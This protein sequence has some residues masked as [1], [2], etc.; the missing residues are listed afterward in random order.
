MSYS[1]FERK[2]NNSLYSVF[3]KN[4]YSINNSFDQNRKNILRHSVSYSNLSNPYSPN[5]NSSPIKYLTKINNLE[6]KLSLLEKTNLNLQN[7]IN[8]NEIIFENRLK[9]IEN[10]INKNEI[11]YNQTDKILSMILNNNS[12]SSNDIKEKII[13]LEKLISKENEF[14]YNQIDL[15]RKIINKLTHQISE[16]IK[17]EISSRFEGDMKNKIQNEYLN[18]SS[19]NEIKNL[20]V[21]YNEII[22]QLKKDILNNENECSQRSHN[23]SKYIDMKINEILN[24]KSDKLQYVIDEIEKIKNNLLSQEDKNLVFENRINNLENFVKVIQDDVYKFIA[25]VEER[26]ISKM[27]DIKKYNEIN[28]KQHNEYIKKQFF[29]FSNVNEKNMIF[30]SEQIADTRTEINNEFNRINKR[31]IEKFECL[32]NDMEQICNRIYKYEDLLKSYDKE[33]HTIKNQI[34]KYLNHFNSKIDVLFVNEKIIHNIEM[35]TIREE[36]NKIIKALNLQNENINNKIKGNQ[37][38]PNEKID[39]IQTINKLENKLNDINDKYFNLINKLQKNQDMIEVKLIMDEISSKVDSSYLFELI[40]KM[41]NNNNI[42]NNNILSNNN[43][44]NE[45][46]NDSKGKIDEKYMKE[47]NLLKKDL[48]NQSNANN[49]KFNTIK[50]SILKIKSEIKYD[51]IHEL[52][53]NSEIKKLETQFTLQQIL[54][55]VEFKNIYSLINKGLFKEN[56]NIKEINLEQDNIKKDSKKSLNISVISDITNQDNDKSLIEAKNNKNM[57]HY[58]ENHLKKVLKDKSFK[59]GNSLKSVSFKDNV[60][61]SEIEKDSDF[62]FSKSSINKN[63]N[64]DFSKNEEDEENDLK[65]KNKSANKGILKK[66]DITSNKSIPNL[67]N[68]KK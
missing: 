40:E 10:I 45:E 22:Y 46:K 28:L 30:L 34:K 68:K 58:N 20:K 61:I 8:E 25:K 4:N 44:K 35:M 65:V 31:E 66:V 18:N 13:Q 33:N 37:K 43:E 48:N 67:K 53:Q 29:F 50:E 3:L 54:N 38:N 42:N 17:L 6:L 32:S 62:S 55:K 60:D 19:L 27:K 36:I 12:L 64:N 7:K 41:Q 9:Q 59:K 11:N 5:T 21:S 49:L 1:P 47:I 16:T 52:K 26:L 23:L 57:F 15:Q 39:L 56:N 51:L 63:I 24:N 14:K 2:I